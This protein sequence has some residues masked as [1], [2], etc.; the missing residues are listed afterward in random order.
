MRSWRGMGGESVDNNPVSE[1]Q[2]LR[3]MALNTQSQMHTIVLDLGQTRQCTF[4]EDA[5]GRCSSKSSIRWRGPPFIDSQ[6][7]D[8]LN[9]H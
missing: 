2:N 5:A 4:K 3:H 7:W 8:A 6:T 9:D 1:A